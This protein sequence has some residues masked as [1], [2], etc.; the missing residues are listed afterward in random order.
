VV[1][2]TYPTGAGHLPGY[3]A[4]PDGEGPWP[5]VV[6]LH[7]VLG[8]TADL[9]RITDRFAANGYLALAPALYG[10]GL[11]IR[12]MISTI[13]AHFAGHGA[14]YDNIE[15]ARHH[16]IANE[17]CT[18]KV[19]L[20][21]FCMGGGFGLQLAPRGLFNATAPNYGL[22]PKNIEALHRSCPVV[23]SFGATDRVVRRGTAAQLEAALAPGN[24]PRD[25][26]EYPNAG[27][28]FMNN[29]NYIPGPIQ[30]ISRIT[31]MAYCEPEAEDAWQRIL[32]FFNEHLT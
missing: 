13:R 18:G 31:G 17:R 8:L 28:S 9:R 3:L 2:I 26:K 27:H 23:A 11:K 10:R 12:C 19:G 7:D 32:T 16:L 14:A 20:V 15:A 21:G 25:V 24:V 29:Y 5:G 1:K 30:F 6:V 4:V 22:L